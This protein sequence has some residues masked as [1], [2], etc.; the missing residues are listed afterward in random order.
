MK[1]A[2][3]A[4]LLVLVI[5]SSACAR[6]ATVSLSESTNQIQKMEGETFKFVASAEGFDPES[7]EFEWDFGD[8]TEPG[9]T[10]GPEAWYL[11]YLGTDTSEKVKAFEVKV[12]A[13]D[14]SSTA[15]DS[16][17]ISVKRDTWKA[18]LNKPVSHPAEKLKKEGEIRVE[19][20]ALSYNSKPYNIA[21]VTATATI[22][23]K[24]VELSKGEGVFYG[25]FTLYY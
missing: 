3:L 10:L 21:T 11:F 15:E 18:R 23:G 5:G 6:A 13:S 14:G 24:E 2:W 19:I 9:K 8:G 1:K 7:L 17:G 16:I 4:L 12:T 22:G 25:S 20:E